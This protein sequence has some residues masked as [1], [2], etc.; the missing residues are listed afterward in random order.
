MLN[1]KIYMKSHQHQSP[2]KFTQIINEEA[3]RA[4][5]ERERN[6]GKR[7]GIGHVIQATKRTR[8]MQSADGKRCALFSPNW[9]NAD[10]QHHA[11]HTDRHIATHLTTPTGR[12][13]GAR[14]FVRRRA[15][16]SF[17]GN[18]TVGGKTTSPAIAA[19]TQSLIPFL[20]VPRCFA[21]LHGF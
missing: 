6:R 1:N 2:N 14:Q 20:Q 4:E 12:R 15:W 3:A 8:T 10:R 13:R 7:L 21:S 11:M 19:K 5:E 16:L 9:M 17:Y 18:L